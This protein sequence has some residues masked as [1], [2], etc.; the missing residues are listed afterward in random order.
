MANTVTAVATLSAAL[1]GGGSVVGSASLSFT[2][3]GSYN[4]AASPVSVG[5]SAA[6]IPV[7]GAT[8]PCW[9][10]IQ[11]LDPANY[12]QIALDSGITEVIAKLTPGSTP[13]CLIPVSTV[14]IYAKAN[15][16]ACNCVIV[17]VDV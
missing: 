13:F 2:Q 16:A 12:V 8:A 5:T 14:T 3:A 17:F 7:G 9:M 15:T 11:N 6:T 4:N 10:F 1:G